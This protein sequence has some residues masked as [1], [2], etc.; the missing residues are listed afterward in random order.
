MKPLQA[1]RIIIIII[2]I[3]KENRV[4]LPA[5]KKYRSLW[6]QS[7]AISRN[8]LQWLE[9]LLTFV[10]IVGVTFHYKLT[11]LK[12][13]LRLTSIFEFSSS[14][15]DLEFRHSFCV[16]NNES[17]CLDNFR[18]FQGKSKVDFSLEIIMKS[19]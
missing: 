16:F 7:P 5:Y 4:W 1:C 10:G 15:M 18:Y 2:I 6:L 9:I 3:K 19:N 12:N 11:F 14:L 13:C 8:C 17:W